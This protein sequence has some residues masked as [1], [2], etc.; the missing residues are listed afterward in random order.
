MVCEHCKRE[1][2]QLSEFDIEALMNSKEK[3]WPVEQKFVYLIYLKS[4]STVL[5]GV[6]S[7]PCFF[8]FHD[9]KYFTTL[10]YLQM[11]LHPHMD[12]GLHAC[13]LFIQKRQ[14]R[15]PHT[16]TKKNPVETDIYKE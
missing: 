3:K 12:H 16:H 10:L 11:N 9:G 4:A 14:I 2:V 5:K 1:D 7:T 13:L 15:S 6:D 8:S